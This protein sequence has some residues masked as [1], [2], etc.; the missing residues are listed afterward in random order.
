[1][2]FLSHI[3]LHGADFP[4]TVYKLYLISNNLIIADPLTPWPAKLFTNPPKIYL[5]KIDNEWQF[6]PQLND[7]NIPFDVTVKLLLFIREL[8]SIKL[9]C[10]VRI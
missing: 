7:C 8:N 6:M 2:V 5:D 9:S 4:Q 10:H 1:M 3:S